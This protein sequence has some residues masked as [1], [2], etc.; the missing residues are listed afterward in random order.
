MAWSW[1]TRTRR[2]YFN[3]YLSAATVTLGCILFVL[4]GDIT[5]PPKPATLD[6]SAFDPTTS[7]PTPTSLVLSFTTMG[8]SLLAIFM[9]FDGLT[10]TS[11]DKL[12][13]SYDM[14]S[15]N[16][17]LYT[18]AWSALLSAG[19]LVITGQIWEA[20]AFVARHPASLWLMVLQSI[21]STSVQLFIVFTIKQY[22]A[23]NF[24]LMMTLRQFLSI[25]LS[26]AVFQHRLSSQQ[27]MGT[28]LVIAGLVTRSLERIG[29]I[30]L[31]DSKGKGLII[32]M[33]GEMR[34]GSPTS[35]AAAAAAAAAASAS[36]KKKGKGGLPQ[37]PTT[38]KVIEGGATL[39][40]PLLQTAQSEE[41]LENGMMNSIGGNGI[42]GNGIVTSTSTKKPSSLLGRSQMPLMNGS[43]TPFVASVLQPFVGNKS[44]VSPLRTGSFSLLT[45]SS[46]ADLKE[47]PT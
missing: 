12:F 33:N 25:V 29:P 45:P 24:A 26:C 38:P 23:L 8:L 37:S 27:W 40:I 32:G 36:A 20:G 16:Q 3:D 1:V 2:Y 44:L 10:C 6:P 34:D 14:H 30:R 13:S 19:F 15:C 46:S 39:T 4:T 18:A 41:Y 31:G 7:T 28:V 21:V 5:A 11:Q 9:I 22:G 47:K 35:V 43:T 17:L 42:G